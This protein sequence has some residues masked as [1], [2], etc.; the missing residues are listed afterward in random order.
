MVAA[1]PGATWAQA[2]SR[3]AERASVA[4]RAPLA[5]A[6]SITPRWNRVAVAP[7][8][9][10]VASRWRPGRCRSTAA[11]SAA[12]PAWSMVAVTWSGVTWCRAATRTTAAH[13]R[14]AEPRVN[15]SVVAVCMNA[16][17]DAGWWWVLRITGNSPESIT[18]SPHL[19]HPGGP[20]EVQ[21]W[22][23]D[24]PDADGVQAL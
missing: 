2:A 11:S 12:R 5:E 14:T 19:E 9:A 10:L 17:W 15:P 8:S 13:W 6:W 3:R 16:A 18:E 7:C 24:S 23:W 21:Q 4:V 20:L 1:R 22:E